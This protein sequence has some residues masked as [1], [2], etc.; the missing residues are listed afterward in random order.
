M[1]HV[2]VNECSATNANG[3]LMHNCDPVNGVCTNPPEGFKCDCAD[4]FVGNGRTCTTAPAPAPS[5]PVDPRADDP[6]FRCLD[7]IDEVCNDMLEVYVCA[8]GWFS[9]ITPH[10]NQRLKSEDPVTTEKHLEV[11]KNYDAE[12]NV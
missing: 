8:P 5:V 11:L 12:H 4:G 1:S 7:R 2:G 9:T 3:E 6:C 10:A